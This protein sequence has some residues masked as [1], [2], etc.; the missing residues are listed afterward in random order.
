MYD[1]EDEYVPREVGY[2][3]PDD[4]EERRGAAT[5]PLVTQSAYVIVDARGL[6]YANDKNQGRPPH[7]DP[8]ALTERRTHPGGSITGSPGQ[9]A[10]RVLLHD[11]CTSLEA[12]VRSRS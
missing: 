9:D 1:I 6:A 10:A 12:V 5:H 3:L 8:R 4:P 7:P 11:L 2:F